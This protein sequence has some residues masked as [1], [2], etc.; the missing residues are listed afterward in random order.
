MAAQ[1]LD[2]AYKIATEVA[3]QF[4]AVD[5]AVRIIGADTTTINTG[6]TARVVAQLKTAYHRAL[7]HYR[8]IDTQDLDSVPDKWSTRQTLPASAIQSADMQ[9]CER[10]L[11]YEPRGD[12]FSG[13]LSHGKTDFDK[14]RFEPE[15]LQR[16]LT[17]VAMLSAYCFSNTIAPSLDKRRDRRA[18]KRA[19]TERWTLSEAASELSAQSHGIKSADDWLAWLREQIEAQTLQPTGDEVQAD[20]VN[21]VLEAHPRWGASSLRLPSAMQEDR[22]IVGW[23]DY[24]M[25]AMDWFAMAAVSP[26]E[27][28][29]LLC[30][31]DPFDASADPETQTN[32]ETGPGDF[33]FT[34]RVF[35]DVH[36]KSPQHRTLVEWIAIAASRAC[37]RHS[38]ISEYLE[39]CA[40]LGF[41]IVDA[42]IKPAT[43]IA[44]GSS[45]ETKVAPVVADI[46][47]APNPMQYRDRGNVMKKRAIIAK[48]KNKWE[49]ID[50]CFKN[51]HANGL[52]IAAKASLR[53][54]WFEAD[55]VAWATK[56]GNIKGATAPAEPKLQTVWTAEAP[57]TP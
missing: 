19:N 32:L 35:E 48:Y 33:A 45:L 2:D 1:D 40:R 28:A 34:L 44:D 15:E 37:K 57:S 56:Q 26:R 8:D 13:W 46:A 22:S 47:S 27:A 53:G 5:A 4:T 12:T 38:W 6:D 25:H 24:T 16:W 51:A 50:S 21:A 43:P 10:L 55:A 54:E 18:P 23:R 30:E 20:D 42:A 14:Q 52:H 31:H 11:Q 39:A 7:S 17:E 9:R 36:S 41:P 3:Q 29:S 49:K